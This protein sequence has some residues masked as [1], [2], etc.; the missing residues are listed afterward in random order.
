MA[1]NESW[2]WFG[3]GRMGRCGVLGRWG[4]RNRAFLI[5]AFRSDCEWRFNETEMRL[6]HKQFSGSVI[7][8]SLGSC[9]GDG[10]GDSI[11]C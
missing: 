5:G 8:R 4:L 10:V 7:V 9:L 3:R 11:V 6:A 2:V 1:S